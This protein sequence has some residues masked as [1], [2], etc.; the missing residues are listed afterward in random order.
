MA[1][2]AVAALTAASLGSANEP[3]RRAAA[4]EAADGEA[5]AGSPS[6]HTEPEA[7]A[8][9]NLGWSQP[10]IFAATAQCADVLKRINAIAIAQPPLKEGS[11]GA[12]APIQLISVGKN[13]QVS[14]SPPATVTCELAETLSQWINDDLQ[15]LAKKTLGGE[16]IAIEVM[17]SYSCRNAYGRKAGRLSEHARANALD[18]RGFTAASGK[19]A[20]VLDDW[21][22]PKREIADRLI[23]AREAAD[24]ATI[25]KAAT[26]ISQPAQA[27]ASKAASNAPGAVQPVARGTLS[28]VPVTT[29]P[30]VTGPIT[31]GPV[32]TTGPVTTGSVSIG[33]PNA[34]GWVPS[35]ALTI[36]EPSRLGGPKLKTGSD[37]IKTAA[38]SAAVTTAAA[39]MNFLR[40]AHAAACQ[41]FGTTLGPESNAAH[42]NHLHVDMALR[43]TTKICDF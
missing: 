10:E 13:P 38:T 17:G 6:A 37:I 29:G 5:A 31:T 34:S 32:A 16:I 27:Q 8:Q 39:K 24:R 35:T 22:T 28:D 19:T 18:I 42:R 12:P 33:K 40:A 23:A 7:P 14:F 9:L 36:S 26:Q 2:C 20:I 1:L 25:A 4:T 43:K 15:P 21:G 3:D 41:R 11:C 30:V